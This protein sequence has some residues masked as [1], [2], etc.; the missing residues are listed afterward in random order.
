MER[1]EGLLVEKRFFRRTD[2]G[3]EVVGSRCPDCD[4]FYF[5][6]K[7]VCPACMTLDRL[8]DEPIGPG[9]TIVSYSVSHDPARGIRTPYAFGYVKLDQGPMIYTLF[10]DCEPVE[11]KLTLGGAVEI[12]IETM[13]K[14]A[15]GNDVMAYKFRPVEGE[16]RSLFS[17]PVS[18]LQG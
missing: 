8:R 9:A 12:V 3:L 16:K 5:P 7:R 4:A 17:R 15:W 13:K 2:D 10:T 18:G 1:S 6:R 11:E 14:D